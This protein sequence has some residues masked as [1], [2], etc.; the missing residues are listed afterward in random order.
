MSC[1]YASDSNSD[2]GS[3]KAYVE[4]QEKG[5]KILN[6]YLW[7]GYAISLGMVVFIGIKYM[8]GAADAR[9]S[10]KSAIVGWLIG[11]FIVFMAT[12]I[13]GLILNIVNPDDST[14]EN[15]SENIVQTGFDLGK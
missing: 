7:F 1:V 4:I 6:A 5:T 11:A 9:A 13:V 15:M 14:V 3:D 8:L 12:T 10:M 2:S